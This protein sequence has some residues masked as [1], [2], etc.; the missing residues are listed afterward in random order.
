[1]SSVLITYRLRAEHVDEH[2]ALLTT[3]HDELRRRRL[4]EV[5]W[6]TYRR[7][8]G[9]SFVELVHTDRPGRFSSLDSWPAFR[10][11][12]EQRCDQR[13]EIVDLELVADAEGGGRSA[14]QADDQEQP[15]QP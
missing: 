8:D 4:D 5:G 1:M 2:L 6:T 12:L 15:W 9:R 3:V 7:E 11:T 10:S 14:Q 13:P